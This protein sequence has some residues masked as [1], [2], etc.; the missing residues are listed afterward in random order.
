MLAVAYLKTKYRALQKSMEFVS[1]A[2]ALLSEGT[3]RGQLYSAAQT[4]GISVSMLKGQLCH[5]SDSFR[6]TR[7]FPTFA[8]F[9]TKHKIENSELVLDRVEKT[10]KINYPDYV[11]DFTMAD[12]NHNFIANHIISHNCGM[13]LL[14]TS[15]TIKEAKPKIRE[16]MELLFKKVPVGVGRKGIVGLEKKD[17]EEVMAK[18]VS[19]T[20]TGGKRIWSEWRKKAASGEQ[21]RKKYR[22]PQ[23]NAVPASWEPWEAETIIWKYN[24]PAPRIFLMPR[25]PRHSEYGEKIR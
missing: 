18:G 23:G 3:K 11:Y 17:F 19:R 24:C 7:D 13:R 10:E 5:P 22:R 15:L 9:C 20:G 4:K 25:P 1:Q 6:A 8:M 2:R 21:T 14:T 16:L 12:E